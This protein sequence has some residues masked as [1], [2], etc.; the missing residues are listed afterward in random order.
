MKVFDGYKEYLNENSVLIGHSLGCL[1]I[2]NLLEK[3]D[4]RIRA[5][6]LVAGFTGFIGNEYFD[7]I[8]K[9]FIEKNFD[10]EKIRKNCK[11]FFVY[12]SDNDHYIPLPMGEELAEKLNAELK[13]IKNAGHF[14]EKSGYTKFEILLND[15]KKIIAKDL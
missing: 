4:I 8:N 1:F 7:T 10:W 13:I 12:G 14:N 5:A 3:L 15:I 6:F 9:T 2:L 11:C